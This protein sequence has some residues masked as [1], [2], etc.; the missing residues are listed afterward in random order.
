MTR[1]LVL[2]TGASSGIGKALARE[3]AA[4]GWDL[5][6]TARREDRL[7]DFAEEMKAQYGV[8]SL[9]IAADLSKSSAPKK[10][11]DAIAAAD[12]QIDGLVNNAGYGLPGT[13]TETSWK[14]Q[15]DFIQLMLTSYAELVHRVMPGMEERG[16]GRI[17]NVASVAGLMP[18]SRGH[19]LY[20]GVK[21]AL[22]KFSQSLYFEGKAHGIH[23]TALCP[24][25]T[26]SE[27]HDV[28]ET[29]GMVSKL[30]KY[31]WL[32]AEQVAMAGFNAVQ[33]NQPVVVPGLW[34]KFLTGLN[35][36]LPND[37]SMWLMSRNSGS[38]RQAEADTGKGAKTATESA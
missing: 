6:L 1:R 24:G 21:S 9:T 15:S 5:A 35:Q 27:F 37:A 33:R 8:D 31:W 11:V 38:F 16:Y 26:Y 22:I 2:V 25:F 36:V 3:F 29:R 7:K 20:A 17:I 13:F 18:G 23:A 10:I 34:Y 12:R 14:Q 30:P 4:N 32:T 28:N 19:T